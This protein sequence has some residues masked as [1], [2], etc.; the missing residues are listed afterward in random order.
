M[1]ACRPF[2]RAAFAWLFALCALAAARADDVREAGRPLW[3]HYTF[4]DYHA[5]HQ[6]WAAVEDANGLVYFGNKGCVLEFDG[7]SWRTLEVPGTTFVRGL[8]IG[9]DDTLYAGGVDE[10]GYFAR[11]PASG[12][13][14]FVSLLD[15]LPVEQREFGDIWRAVAVGDAVYFCANRQLMRWRGGAFH[16][17][18]FQGDIATTLHRVGD[19]VYV[20]RAGEPLQR[21][22]GEALVPAGDGPLERGA[23]LPAIVPLDRGRLLLCSAD[24]G[25]AVLGSDGRE[26][27]FAPELT[28]WL[29]RENVQ[30]AAR[31][32]DLLLITT[33]R[34]GVLVLDLEGHFARRLDMA[35]GLRDGQVKHV[36]ES[37][38]GELWFCLNN[39]IARLRLP[40][41]QTVFAREQGLDGS[42][43]RAAL[44]YEGR[45]HVATAAG[46]FRLVPADPAR[47]TN[48]RFERVPGLRGLFY[49]LAEMPDGLV[50][51][52][53]TGIQ[54]LPR[55]GGAAVTLTRGSSA[56]ALLAST[57][58]PGRLWVGTLGGLVRLDRTATGWA[59]TPAREP[60]RFEVRSIVEEDDG[61]LWLGTFTRGLARVRRPADAEPERRFYRGGDAGLPAGENGFHVRRAGPQVFAL[62]TNGHVLRWVAAEQRFVPATRD[63]AAT[64]D[65]DVWQIDEPSP[66][67]GDAA[68]GL[69]ADGRYGAWALPEVFDVTGPLQHVF[70]ERDDRGQA[71]LW[72]SGAEAVGRVD[73]SRE[74]PP[75]PPP[76]L[77]LRSVRLDDGARWPERGALAPGTHRVLFGLAASAFATAAEFSTRLEGWED[78]WSPWSA[79]RER[80]FTALPPGDYTFRARVRSGGVE[81]GGE[82]AYPFAIAAPWWAAWWA[83]AAVG[84]FGLVGVVIVVG[85]RIRTLRRR[86]AELEAI[87]ARRT[88][89]LQASNEQLAVARDAAEAANRAKSTFLAHM[90]HELRTPLNGVLGYAQVLARDPAQ[91][92]A[93]RERL[94]II[95]QSG[96]HLLALINEVLDLARVEAGKM[97]LRPTTCALPRLVESVADLMRAPCEAAGLGFACAVA[98]G[99]PRLV[100]TDEQ[101]LRQVLLNLVGNAVKFARHGA[102]RL[103]VAPLPDGRVRFEVSDTGVGIAPERL[104]TLFQPF[105]TSA[106]HGAR[107]TGLGLALSRSMVELLGGRLLAESRPGEGARFWFDLPLPEAASDAPPVSCR[108]G[109]VTGYRGPRRRLLVVDDDATNRAVL[110]ELLEPL[111][112]DVD[113]AADAYAALRSARERRPDAVLLDL[114]FETGPD[115]FEIARRLRADAGLSDTWIIAVSASVFES[116]RHQAIAAGCDEFLAKPF[117]EAQLH[118]CL[119]AALGLEWVHAPAAPAPL[120]AEACPLP[121]EARAELLELARRGDARRLAARLGEWAER[122]EFAVEARRLQEVAAG[123]QMK[124][125]REMLSDHDENGAHH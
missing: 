85:W 52:E 30:T 74:R 37:R 10:L 42:S 24:R 75:L 116:D 31:A 91:P 61:S 5:H 57:V 79:R 8:A 106:E 82:V 98:A 119:G 67:E 86:G 38:S 123:F 125:L 115:G 59:L 19:R 35:D 13:K 50:A 103:A 87:V 77:V 72:L 100:R 9:P 76:G 21:I 105:A 46:V 81:G 18:S 104:A 117:Q 69:F 36:L 51:G 54:L 124:R 22:D 7:E 55:D 56:V 20:H 16:V 12:E 118:A 96:E 64:P 114:R 29:R 90:S 63:R 39:G 66:G 28:E 120:A 48:A 101:K 34:A 95:I 32:G 110:R 40:F 15:R 3:R 99:L 53:Q 122:P 23:R 109:G 93:A 102:V 11:D 68:I 84:L 14:R 62:G 78:D 2:P 112:F 94:Q 49:S 27:A 4:R 17:W 83:R 25:L 65:T 1:P 121:E 41:D 73:L 108:G 92:P 45:L 70:G 47:L 113:E 111:G 89:E 97:Q 88:A 6:V 26:T 71:W 33:R 44:R 107:G 58:T 43:V 80:E 60:L